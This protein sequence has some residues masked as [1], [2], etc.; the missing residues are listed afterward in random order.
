MNL[1]SEIVTFSFG[2]NWRSFVDTV[3]EDSVARALE[4]IE[5]WLGR[6]GVAGKSIIDIGSGSGIHSLCFHMLGAE[7]VFS[8]DVDPKSVESTRLL[9][10]KA[11]RPTNW[12]VAH[13]SIL[14]SDF[15]S[16]IESYDL[17]YSWGVLH[18]TGSMW[19]AIENAGRLVKK[20]GLF[21]IAIYVK[22]ETYERD[23]RLKRSYNEATP[24][25]K[26]MIEWRE[27]LRIMRKRLSEG[28]NPL[29]WNQKRGRGM[30]TYHDLVDWLG[31]L[32][33]E[34]ATADE[35][36]SFCEARGFKLKRVDD[37]E[38]NIVYL[39]SRES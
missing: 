22:G 4:N 26:K 20:S 19:Q 25:G 37:R 32:P 17:V 16:T 21:W 1:Q 39:F 12:T 27:I 36:V 5:A 18:H 35:I 23:L 3:S 6:E 33:Y 28:K 9:W 29:A 7:R 8:L 24:F 34:V 15:V 10:Q 14:D 2:K 13:G 31:G 30:N 11:G 38:A